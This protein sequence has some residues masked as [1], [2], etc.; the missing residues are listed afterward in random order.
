MET[1]L[2][3]KVPNSEI[4][5]TKEMYN[6]NICLDLKCGSLISLINN[7]LCHVGAAV[8]SSGNKKTYKKLF[9]CRFLFF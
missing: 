4:F 1:G 7:Y 6:F 2:Y 3:F 8:K 5:D 9:L